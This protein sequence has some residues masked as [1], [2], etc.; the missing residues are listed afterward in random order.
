MDSSLVL[1]G[2]DEVKV[3]SDKNH[4]GSIAAATICPSSMTVTIDS[5]VRNFPNG[6]NPNL[7][8]PM[9]GSRFLQACV[10]LQC[11]MVMSMPL[12]PYYE[13]FETWSSTQS[14]DRSLGIN[15]FNI[16]YPANNIY[17][18][19]LTITLDSGFSVRIPN[20]QL[21]LSD[22]KISD[23]GHIVSNTSVRAVNIYSLQDVNKNNL[24]RLGYFFFASTY[25]MVDHDAATFTIWEANPTT[26]TEFIA[27]TANDTADA[28]TATAAAAGP[29]ATTSRPT[30]TPS[31]QVQETIEQTSLFKGA[32]GCIVAGGIMA[33]TAVG[34]SLIW[35][36]RRR[37]NSQSQAEVPRMEPQLKDGVNI[38]SLHSA[39]LSNEPPLRLG[40]TESQELWAGDW[41][42]SSSKNMH[43]R[44]EMG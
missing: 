14:I 9:F 34:L 27:I 8:D 31:A 33:S 44:Y 20:S 39:E 35:L 6:A 22:Q 40:E 21:V 18:G 32:I 25:L 26:G 17:Q 19:D 12:D 16:I 7:L 42:S 28:C 23:A 38:V 2:Y 15:F 43:Q 41:R 5:I 13:R 1:G 3:K 36:L 10:C 24:P 29:A 4:T 11:S 37:K 30:T